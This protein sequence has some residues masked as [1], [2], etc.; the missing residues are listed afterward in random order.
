MGDI[1]AKSS[2]AY[3]FGI[4]SPV[5]ISVRESTYIT[6][7]FLIFEDTATLNCGDRG[8]VG[9]AGSGAGARLLVVCMES[10]RAVSQTQPWV[11]VCYPGMAQEN[12][13]EAHRFIAKGGILWANRRRSAERRRVVGT[14][15]VPYARHRRAHSLAS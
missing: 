5:D 8:R 4:A 12:P 11:C 6:V 2:R 3:A 15:N 10:Q 13:T 9:G 1:S 7:I 14:T